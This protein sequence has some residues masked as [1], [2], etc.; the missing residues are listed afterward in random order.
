MGDK[1]IKE[2]GESMSPG[3]YK[4]ENSTISPGLDKM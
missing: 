4:L 2:L 1:Y 3:I